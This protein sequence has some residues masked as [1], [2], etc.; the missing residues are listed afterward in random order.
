MDRDTA[1]AKIKKCL[2]LGRSAEPHEAAAAMRQAQKLMDMF[3]VREHDVSMADVREVSARA[4]GTAISAWDAS[5]A[6]MCA[7]AFGCEMYS[8]L[9][10]DYNEAGNFVRTRPVVFVGLDAAADVAA[11]AYQV[12]MRQCARDRM[13]HI[14]K[15]PRNCKP[16]TKTARGDAF[17]RGWV[18]SVRELVQRFAQ[19]A[20]DEQLLLAYMAERH[21][22]LTSAPTRD[23]SRQRKTDA[24]HFF[25]GRAA[26]ERADLHRAVGGASE[27]ALLS[28][29]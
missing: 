15:Q 27:P 17:A 9:R 10:G 7:D 2:A 18:T 11:Y 24:G 19:P 12:L 8:E 22:Y 21:P 28:G 25:L 3:N 6:R 20:Q 23:A 26:G 14:R 29:A 4:S 13:A 1:I 5:L 16:L